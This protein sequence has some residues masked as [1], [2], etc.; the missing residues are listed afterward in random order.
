MCQS[1]PRA[2]GLIER[3]QGAEVGLKTVGSDVDASTDCASEDPTV[4]RHNQ[5]FTIPPEEND[6][7]VRAC[8][9]SGTPGAFEVISIC[10]A[11]AWN[12]STRCAASRGNDLTC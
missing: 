2:S 3:C 6:G 9:A 5:P 11:K 4:R 7:A 8:A 1:Y 12:A 10:L